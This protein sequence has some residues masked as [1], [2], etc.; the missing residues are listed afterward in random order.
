MFSLCKGFEW[1]GDKNREGRRAGLMPVT[2]TEIEEGT[3]AW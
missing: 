2:Q 3:N 1:I